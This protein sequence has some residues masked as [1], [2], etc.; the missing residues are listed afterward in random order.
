MFRACI[1]NVQAMVPKRQAVTVGDSTS[2]VD[3]ISGSPLCHDAEGAVA[4]SLPLD[5]AP[6]PLPRSIPHR[7]TRRSFNAAAEYVRS[8]AKH[9]TWTILGLG[10]CRR[11]QGGPE[12]R[13]PPSL[14]SSGQVNF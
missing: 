8:T 5:L 14:T 10:L 13:N 7:R 12:G 4:R 6:S 11:S 1:Y 2:A 9:V 3:V